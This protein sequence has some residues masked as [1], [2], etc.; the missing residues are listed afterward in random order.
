MSDSI[1]A[2]RW[3]PCWD[4][5]T[6]QLFY[7]NKLTCHRVLEEPVEITRA[8]AEQSLSPTDE[9]PEMIFRKKRFRFLRDL[10]KGLSP[11]TFPLTLHRNK[12]YEETFTQF[13]RI[14]KKELQ[15]KPSISYVDEAGMDA[16]G[17]TK[18][19]YLALSKAAL[20]EDRH[21]FTTDESGHLQISKSSHF[22]TAH[23]KEF[24]FLGK[25]I[26]KAI[27][28]RNVVDLPLSDLLYKHILG[29][30]VS[31]ADLTKM[32]LQFSNSLTWM[33]NHDITD[34]LFE[35]FSIS[36]EDDNMGPN[37][38]IIDL[39]ENGRNINVTESNK[40]EYV[41]AMTTWHTEFAIRPQLDAFLQG[42]HTLL[43]HES[44]NAFTVPELKLLFNGK[45]E[46][47]VDEIR[48]NCVFQGG[49]SENE[50]V[51]LWL[52]QAIREFN[53]EYKGLFLKFVTGTN[54]IPLDGFD[55]S[56]NVTKSD[57]TNTAF[58]RTHTCF[59]QLVLPE[60]T[61]Y[62]ILVE[63]I[64]FAIVNCDGFELS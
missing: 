6:Q 41:H 37:P 27:F 21:L 38:V 25:V 2:S 3:L 43:P 58:P 55:P 4:P 5:T 45:S 19:W 33:L 48:S 16:G 63:K 60:Y 23:L 64:M 9:T 46:I 30:P 17:L 36:K 18:D 28:D 42:L 56:F 24:R 54:K 13:T 62:E 40:M 14:G 32:D 53:L 8:R 52:W 61:S 51:V 34:I 7:F 50:K 20:T 1:A 26:G 44:L 22:N 59:N 47:N 39:I 10:R 29:L 12:V 15:S 11:S 49:Y 35:T 31:F 57:L